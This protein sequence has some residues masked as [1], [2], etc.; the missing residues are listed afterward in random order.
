[1]MDR[2]KTEDVL[3]YAL[4]CA[5]ENRQSLADA[6]GNDDAEEAVRD[7]K[8]DIAA[9]RRLKKRLFGNRKSR[10]EQILE[11]PAKVINIFEL[12]KFLNENPELEIDHFQTGE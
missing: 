4:N 12:R 2:R 3:F 9:F 1:M 11:Q 10:K 7:A 6:W 8:M 5:I